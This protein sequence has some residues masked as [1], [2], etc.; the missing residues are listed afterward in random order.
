MT[1]LQRH[2]SGVEPARTA[3]G[4]TNGFGAPGGASWAA[5]VGLGGGRALSAGPGDASGFRVGG[6][7]RYAVATGAGASDGD[8]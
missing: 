1:S 8:V 3:P 2:A 7:G 6:G 5:A 4:S